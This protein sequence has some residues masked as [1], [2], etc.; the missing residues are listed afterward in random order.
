MRVPLKQQL[1]ELPASE[2]PS[3]RGGADSAPYDPAP[4]A[5][6]R[7]KRLE[8]LGS[9]VVW[10]DH[11]FLPQVL[12][13]EPLAYT[14]AWSPKLIE[15][16]FAKEVS[17]R[18]GL[19]LHGQLVGYCFSYLVM[20]E[21]HVLNLAIHPEWQGRGLGRLLLESVLE[22]A[23][24]R[25]AAYVTLEVRRSNLIAQS[26]YTSL[27]FTEAGVRKNYYRDNGE[28]ALVLDRELAAREM[29]TQRA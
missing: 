9:A 11:A 23:V 27:G 20:D 21:L 3:D 15:G 10:L 28:D 2:G 16:E 26:L 24:S 5:S 18:W 19:L 12:A 29:P 8:T 25:G 1:V 7:L 4:S 14:H 17:F 6:A 22:R 13:L